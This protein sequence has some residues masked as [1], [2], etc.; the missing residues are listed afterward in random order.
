M[1][2]KLKKSEFHAG[3]I[4][5]PHVIL[6]CPEIRFAMGYPERRELRILWGGFQKILHPGP[7]SEEP[8]FQRLVH[9]EL[10]FPAHR[11]SLSRAVRADRQRFPVHGTAIAWLKLP[12]CG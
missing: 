6:H 1:M 10:N 3:R 9:K 7:V 5:F 12:G 4:A 11:Y 8:L 2:K